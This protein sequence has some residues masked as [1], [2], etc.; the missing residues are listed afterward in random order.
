MWGC[1][2][3]GHNKYDSIVS[4]RFYHVTM[5]ILCGILPSTQQYWRNTHGALV[6]Y[7]ITDHMSLRHALE[8]KKHLDNNVVQQDGNCIPAVLLGNKV[9]YS[10]IFTHT[11]AKIICSVT[12]WHQINNCLKLHQQFGKNTSLLDFL[13]LQQ[14]QNTM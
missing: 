4:V 3:V 1:V 6:M 10:I 14:N 7:D 5:T 8:W 9:L 12:R 2:C 11:H 13:Q